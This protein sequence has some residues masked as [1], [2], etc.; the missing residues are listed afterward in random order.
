MRL[1]NRLW[2]DILVGITL[3]SLVLFGSV[4]IYR[5]N[6]DAREQQLDNE[7]AMRRQ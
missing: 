6:N 1:Y 4:Y 5:L 7:V 2:L 3:T